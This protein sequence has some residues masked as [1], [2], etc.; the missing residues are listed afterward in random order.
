[1]QMN[2]KRRNKLRKLAEE[3][4]VPQIYGPPEG[5]VLLV[6]WGSTK[7]PIEEA[8]E[9]ARSMATAFPRSLK[10][11]QSAAE[12]PREYLLRLQPC[13]RRRNERRRPLRLRPARRHPAR[14]LLRS[15]IRGINKTDGLTWKVKEILASRAQPDEM[16]PHGEHQA[17]FNHAP[18]SSP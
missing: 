18:R 14:A 4:P 1:M 12:R 17:I 5:N 15:E 9:R 2:A 7:G 8:V 13:P 3:L 11:P 6:G 16:K 10:A